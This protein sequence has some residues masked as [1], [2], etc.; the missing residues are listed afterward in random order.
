MDDVVLVFEGTGA[1]A[2]DSL[3]QQA[4]TPEFVGFSVPWN[5]SDVDPLTIDARF[6]AFLSFESWPP[7]GDFAITRVEFEGLWVACDD[8]SPAASVLAQPVGQGWAGL[9]DDGVT[10]DELWDAVA[11]ETPPWVPTVERLDATAWTPPVPTA[12]ATVTECASRGRG[13][14]AP[15]GTTELDD[16]PSLFRFHDRNGCLVN[17]GD[18]ALYD[19]ELGLSPAEAAEFECSPIP[20]VIWM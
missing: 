7:A 14:F 1:A 9:L 17:S 18:V 10:L 3:G 16:P 2:I 4:R 6:V 8:D 20:V 11:I 15:V 12:Q 19:L 13:A 5:G